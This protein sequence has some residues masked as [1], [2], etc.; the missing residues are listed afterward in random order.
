MIPATCPASSVS[1]D[2]AASA[3]DNGDQPQ[4]GRDRFCADAYVSSRCGSTANSPLTQHGAGGRSLPDIVGAV[5]FLTDD[6]PG[7]LG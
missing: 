4:P 7:V 2:V 5:A 1:G 6:E 3:V